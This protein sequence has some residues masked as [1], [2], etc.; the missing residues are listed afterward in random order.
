M[1]LTAGW[2]PGAQVHPFHFTELPDL[3]G[4]PSAWRERV[5]PGVELVKGFILLADPFTFDSETALSGLDYAYPEVAKLGGL[6]SG[7]QQAGEAALFC[8]RN[9]HRE[10]CVGLAFSGEVEVRPVVAQGCDPVGEQLVITECKGNV[11]M[12]LGGKPAFRA[13]VE[14][15]EKLSPEQRLAAQRTLF[16]GLG[17]G[18]PALKYEAG[19]FLVRQVLGLDPRTGCM[20]VG[21]TMRNGQT[22]QFHLRDAKTSAKDL[23]SVLTRFGKESGFGPPKGALLFSCLGRGRSLYGELGHDSKIFREIMGEL[24]LG[25]FFCNG[26][27][28]P[29]GGESALHG[30]TSSFAIFSESR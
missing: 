5:A 11:I 21:A 4:P 15:M 3:D 27:F 8:G 19:D 14:T 10:G 28:G 16:V 20:A 22:V 1:S 6:A 26:E 25:G 24:P 13:L 12:E 23:R 17:A 7:C 18:K 29:V 2:L 30:F 9:L